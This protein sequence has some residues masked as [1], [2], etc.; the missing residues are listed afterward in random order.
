MESNSLNGQATVKMVQSVEKI[1]LEKG[2]KYNGIRWKF[3][4]VQEFLNS[5]LHPS[6]KQIDL[7]KKLEQRT[8]IKFTGDL[9]S[10]KDVSDYINAN[11]NHSN[12]SGDTSNSSDY[13]GKPSQKQIDYLRSIEKNK[14]VVFLGDINSRKDVMAFLDE[15]TSKA[16]SEK[17]LNLI[18]IIESRLN[19]KYEG[20]SIKEA[21]EFINT[22]KDK[23]DSAPKPQK[24][25]ENTESKE[26][27]EVTQKMKDYV[28]FIENKLGI[29]FTG[30]KTSF[31]KVSEF[32]SKYK[33]QATSK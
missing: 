33:D 28:K 31:T 32:I 13:N 10:C 2:I 3:E 18:S 11:L 15:H 26:K 8:N 4:D 17:Q 7:V 30:S 14:N 16:P 25:S 21:S 23:L 6:D 24:S 22:Y 29:P 19:V 5:H 12:N 27:R 9:T 1:E 20:H